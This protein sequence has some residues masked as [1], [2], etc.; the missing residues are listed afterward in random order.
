LSLHIPAGQITVITG[1]SGVGKTTLLE[2]L[3]GVQ[4]PDAGRV[5]VCRETAES[6]GGGADA[7]ADAGPS[8]NSPAGSAAGAVGEGL[9]LSRIDP[10][11][12]RA[13]LAWA[14]QG[15]VIQAGSV[16]DNLAL[17]NAAAEDAVLRAALDAVDASGFVDDLPN[18]WDTELGEGGAGI[19]Q[20][21]RQRL[22]LARA[23]ARPASLVL[24]DEPTAALDE[25]TERRVLAGIA[26]TVRGRTVVLVT[27]RS[28][29]VALADQVVSLRSD[30][31]ASTAET[32]ADEV[33]PLSAVGPW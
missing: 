17:G 33:E 12:W 13:R 25:A 32:S 14:G 31:P 4:R 27:H 18:G 7:F 24:L 9:D 15:A 3:A 2:L 10:V 20:G 29:P 19:S 22:A 8:P 1:D 16:R 28:A 21:Q 23:L 11:Q 5:V 26:Q 6:T 30:D